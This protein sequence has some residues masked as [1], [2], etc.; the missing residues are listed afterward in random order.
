[1][2]RIVGV[3]RSLQIGWIDVLIA[4]GLSAL[5]IAEGSGIDSGDFSPA[6]LLC[7]APLVVRRR[8]PIP[9]L[10]A[11]LFGFS[12][13][14]NAS[15]LASL[16]GGLIAAVSVGL[17]ERHPVLGTIAV[18]A[19]ATGIAL[20]FGRGAYTQ[21]PIPGFLAP[22]LLIGAAFL[23]GRVIADRQQQLKQQRDRA[24]ELERLHDVAVK[25][26]AEAERRHIAR[27]LHDVIAHS[28][29]VMVVQAGAARHIL[30]QKPDA[31]RESLL[32]VEA[33]GHEAMAE[34]R[35]LLGVL[36]E[37]GEAAPMSPQSG[38][39]ALESLVSRIR[40]AG[41]PVELR[42]EGE[43]RPLPPGVDVAAYRI[44]QEALTIALKY[45]GGAPTQAVIRYSGEA[46][47]I[48]VVDEGEVR[49]AGE[50]IG[51][52]LTGMRE[53][54]AL[55]GGTLDTGRREGGGYAVRAH[56]PIETKK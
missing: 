37:N 10:L 44:V 2:G 55:F 45:A 3:A 35:R 51:R 47:D 24:N 23:A 50:G 38:V 9:V 34:L 22:F 40:E 49:T 12:I 43:R 7:T 5:A 15:N 4:V 29:G 36:N 18:A 25:A 13:A 30:T 21:L 33:S 53:R 41:L 28:V 26:A 6:V 54:V 19:V 32:A 31:A 42:L 11:A 56:L 17:D 20:E 1:M 27:E 52:G 39:G 46:I 8:W 14:G 16:A 48:E